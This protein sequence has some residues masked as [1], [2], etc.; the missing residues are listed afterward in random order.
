[1]NPRKVQDY[2]KRLKRREVFL[3]ERIG[4]NE[5]AHYD[6]AELAALKWIIRYAEDTLLEAS[7]HQAKYFNEMREN[8]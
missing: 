6:K 8:G 3:E 5:N 7:E 2:L 1:M 4:D